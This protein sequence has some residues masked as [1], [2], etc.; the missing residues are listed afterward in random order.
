MSRSRIILDCRSAPSRRQR[1]PS[2]RSASFEHENVRLFAICE[3]TGIRLYEITTRPRASSLITHLEWLWP[4]PR[5]SDEGGF[6][7]HQ[8]SLGL[9]GMS[10][11]YGSN[12]STRLCRLAAW[13]IWMRP[14]GTARGICGGE[15]SVDPEGSSFCFLVVGVWM[16]TLSRLSVDSS[17]DLVMTSRDR[18]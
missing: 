9:D 15:W 12:R 17:L 16:P 8:L 7:I 14:Y 13:E 1:C 4:E 6:E 18:T 2:G 11:K 3:K 5:D 10:Y